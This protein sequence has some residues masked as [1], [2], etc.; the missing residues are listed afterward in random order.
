M[1]RMI[2]LEAKQL[3]NG[4]LTLVEIQLPPSLDICIRMR[5]FNVRREK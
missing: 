1:R 4:S 3:L 5:V 2:S